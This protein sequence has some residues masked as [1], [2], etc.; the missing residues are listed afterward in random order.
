MSQI[1]EYRN[2]LKK[3]LDTFEADVQLMGSALWAQMREIFRLRRELMLQV[4]MRDEGEDT[5]RTQRNKGRFAEADYYFALADMNK[6]GV[7]DTMKRLQELDIA[8]MQGQL[9]KGDIE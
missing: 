5:A 4:V 3:E 6:G 9:G 2:H 1:E 8:E 7:A